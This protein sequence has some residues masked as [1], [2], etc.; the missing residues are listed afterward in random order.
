MRQP[1]YFPNYAVEDYQ[2]WEGDWEL[3]DGMPYA[4]SPSANRRHHVIG[5]LLARQIGKGLS[6]L[7]ATIVSRYKNSIGNWIAAQW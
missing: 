3:I 1:K 2:Q 5:S 7:P 4:M 6:K